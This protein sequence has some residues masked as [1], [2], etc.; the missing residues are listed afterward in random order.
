M[1][2]ATAEKLCSL[3]CG[4]TI[5]IGA[6]IIDGAVAQTMA[7]A[8]ASALFGLGGYAVGRSKGK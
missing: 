4:T 5:V 6:L 7:I 2:D 8:C 3:I 1:K